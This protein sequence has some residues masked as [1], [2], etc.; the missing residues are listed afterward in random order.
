MRVCFDA[1]CFSAR[2]PAVVDE[3]TQT[4][5]CKGIES[6]IAVLHPGR[7]ASA[8]KAAPSNIISNSNNI[9]Q[10]KMEGQT[11]GPSME[12]ESTNNN[13]VDG[14]E[15]TPVVPQPVDGTSNNNNME[16]DTDDLNITIDKCI[17][18]LSGIDFDNNSLTDLCTRFEWTP[19][20]R[21][22]LTIVQEKATRIKELEGRLRQKENEIA[23]LR[24]HLDKFQSVFPFSRARQAGNN[25]NIGQRQRAQ[26]ISAEPQNETSVL[27][28]LH[29]TFPKYQKD[30][31]YVLNQFNVLFIL[32]C[33]IN[34][35]LTTLF[36]LV[37]PCLQSFHTF[38]IT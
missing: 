13:V 23:E 37:L 1:L 11:D 16:D 28:M 14:K 36:Y 29:V 35:M 7:D 3:E 15:L 20:E 19:N 17:E 10:P 34:R 24:S 31:K 2:R 27:E 21:K 9:Y 12:I 33:L 6:S 26:G 38:Q 18:N 30:G 8:N 25:G 4:A 22:L 32:H 5:F